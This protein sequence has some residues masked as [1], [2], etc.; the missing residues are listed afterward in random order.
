MKCWTRSEE[1]IFQYMENHSVMLADKPSK[2]LRY[3]GQEDAWNKIGGLEMILK[4]QLKMLKKKFMDKEKVC[5][6]L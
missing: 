3:V 4:K 5:E 1:D 6:E 2:H